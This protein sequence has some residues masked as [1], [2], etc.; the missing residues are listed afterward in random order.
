MVK[1]EQNNQDNQLALHC[2]SITLANLHHVQVITKTITR[3][4]CLL[5]LALGWFLVRYELGFRLTHKTC[6]TH[7]FISRAIL[8][9]RE[10]NHCN[11]L[12]CNSVLMTST[13][14][15][16]C[17]SFFGTCLCIDVL[18]LLLLLLLLL[19]FL[20]LFMRPSLALVGVSVIASKGFGST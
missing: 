8:W 9:G 5:F 15:D 10:L 18:L 12:V 19:C 17:Y 1:K 7:P 13:A 2:S 20:L 14:I 6:L 3:S 11:F 16:V 4:L